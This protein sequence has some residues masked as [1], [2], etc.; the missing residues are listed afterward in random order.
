M[1][2]KERYQKVF[3]TVSSFGMELY[4]YLLDKLMKKTRKHAY[5]GTAAAIAAALLIAAA[6]GSPMQQCGRHTAHHPA[7]DSWRPD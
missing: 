1:T 2:D 3:D 7:L 4:V 6:P 5:M